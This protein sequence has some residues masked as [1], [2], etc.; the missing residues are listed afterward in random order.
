MLGVGTVRH[1]TVSAAVCLLYVLIAALAQTFRELA[2]GAAIV[3]ASSGVIAVTARR[4]ILFVLTAFLVVSL[5]IPALLW[6]LD[7]AI[8]GWPGLPF[9]AAAIGAIAPMVGLQWWNLS[10]AVSRVQEEAK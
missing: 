5:L 4:W 7:L 6:I 2:L 3:A 10:W 8:S 1:L 9:V